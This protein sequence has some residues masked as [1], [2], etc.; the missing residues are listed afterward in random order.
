MDYD[1]DLPSAHIRGL[2]RTDLPSAS[3]AAAMK[4]MPSFELATL[5][6]KRR[7]RPGHCGLC[8]MTSSSGFFALTSAQI[9]SF[10]NLV[11]LDKYF[12]VKLFKKAD[13]CRSC[14]GSVQLIHRYRHHLMQ[15]LS[16]G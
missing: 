5:L 11:G 13:Y 6:S 12:F 14:Q 10:C 16:Q 2:T 7:T 4:S 9:E 3:A 1:P 8:Y 15:L